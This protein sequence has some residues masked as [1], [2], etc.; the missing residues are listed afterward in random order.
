MKLADRIKYKRNQLGKTL[1]EVG[2]KVGVTKATI[3]RYEN[4]NIQNIPS[5]KIE[6]LAAALNTTPAYLMGWEDDKDKEKDKID[7]SNIPGVIPV[8]KIIKIPILGHIQCGKPV[9]SVENYEGYFTADPE[10]INSDFCLYA[11]GD[12]MIDAGIH[13]G[14]LVFFK[15]TPQVE[16]G[17]IAAVFIDDTTTLKRF[18]KKENQIILQPENKSY[19]PIIINLDESTNIRILG[20]MVGMYVKGS[21]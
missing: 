2:Q 21:K 13:E 19:S 5:D 10:M 12:S 1:E 8:K 11:D 4:G 20:E 3:Q 14:D 15:Q 6:L 7:L 18:Y 9:M 17:S 16:N